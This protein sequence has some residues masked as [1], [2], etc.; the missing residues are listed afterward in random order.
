[1][2]FARRKPR[3]WGLSIAYRI[4]RLLPRELALDLMLDTAWIA[5]RLAHENSVHLGLFRQEPNDFLLREIGPDDRVLELGC[6]TGEVIGSVLAKRRLG[7]DYEPAKIAAARGRFPGVEFV[8]GDLRDYL[9]QPFNVL[10]LSHVLEHL[11]DPLGVLTTGNFARIYVEVP[12]FD[13]DHLNKVRLKRGRSLVYS[14]DDHVRELTREEAEAMFEEAGLTVTA[15]E[16]RGGVMRFWLMRS[17][18]GRSRP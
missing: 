7:I 5:W 12:D 6:G 4:N 18:R 11:D 17:A 15:S 8:V 2:E 16:F 3:H 13:A 9:D 1:M 10:I 14:D